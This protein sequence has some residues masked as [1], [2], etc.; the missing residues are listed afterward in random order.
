[1]C[2]KQFSSATGLPWQKGAIS[3][4]KWTGVYMVDLLKLVNCDLNNKQIKHVIAEGHDFDPASKPYSASV[5][6][7][8]ALD[9]NNKVLIAYKMNDQAIPRDHGF[10]VRFIAPG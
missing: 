1:M 7:E 10:P 5:Q 4:A 2:D 9:P 6:S 8:F 3:N